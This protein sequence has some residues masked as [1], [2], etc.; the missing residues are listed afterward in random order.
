MHRFLWSR[1]PL[2]NV[3]EQ[4]FLTSQT[5]A[6]RAQAATSPAF[7]RS[8]DDLVV[9]SKFCLHSGKKGTGLVVPAS[10]EGVRVRGI[11]QLKLVLPNRQVEP[12]P[13]R[14]QL[15]DR[16]LREQHRRVAVV[17]IENDSL[18]GPA[19]AATTRGHKL[20]VSDAD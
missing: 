7:V 18:R 14:Q 4:A 17:D 3:G 20:S 6:R 9:R 2:G 16:E 19:I 11:G 10:P 1:S 5:S 12:K 13:V 15:L 8:P